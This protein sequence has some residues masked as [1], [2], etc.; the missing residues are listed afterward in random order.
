MTGFSRN[1]LDFDV[2]AKAT[3]LARH[4]SDVVLKR[5]RRRGI[6]VALS[7]GIDSS[8]VAALA[9]RALGPERVFGIM[10]PER[11]SSD[12]SLRLA[13]QL[14]AQLGIKYEVQEI[15]STLEAIGCYRAR[16]EAVRSVFPSFTRDCRWKIAMHGDRLGS[17]VLNV[18]YLVVRT[19]NGQEERIRLTPSAYLQIVAATNFKQRVRK[20]LEYYH[21][22]RLVF[23]VAATPNRLEYDQ[24]FFV[25]LGDGAGDVKPIA[26]MYKSQVYR[27]AAHLGVPQSIVDRAPT[28][29]TYSLEQ[30]QQEFY[31]S[32]PYADLD[33]IL[34]GKNHGAA[35]ELVARSLSLSS[36][37]VA[38]VYADIDQKRRTTAY[39]HAAPFLLEPVPE[40]AEFDL[41]R[42]SEQ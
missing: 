14:A 41:S 26:S 28:T 24:G 4:L 25:K 27:M 22:D 5:L 29:D 34:W 38:R 8:C 30:S 2:D 18:F 36:E 20:T 19:P 32:V 23:A 10:L 11:D 35:P 17:D 37:Q 9:V 1:V 42:T 31:F 3:Q 40:L 16:E 6:V 13:K 33:L 12:D 15:A 21:A 7:G 39:L